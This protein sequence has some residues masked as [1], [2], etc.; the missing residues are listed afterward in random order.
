MS[1]VASNFGK[2][3]ISDFPLIK[4]VQMRSFHGLIQ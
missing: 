4:S 1:Q 2:Y 3:A